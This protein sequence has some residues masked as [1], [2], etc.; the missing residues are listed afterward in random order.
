MPMW[1]STWAGKCPSGAEEDESQCVPGA[2]AQ[3]GAKPA[4]IAV[5]MGE[6]RD[7]GVR[8]TRP[9]G[10]PFKVGEGQ[11][12]TGQHTVSQVLVVSGVT[13]AGVVL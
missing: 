11:E 8:V 5:V 10:W 3:M 6:R 2:V 13:Q 9:Q 4:E 7:L 1:S 12:S